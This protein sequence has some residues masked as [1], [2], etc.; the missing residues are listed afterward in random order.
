MKCLVIVF[1]HKVGSYFILWSVNSFTIWHIVLKK[2]LK[3]QQ[4]TITK[5][6]PLCWQLGLEPFHR[7]LKQEMTLEPFN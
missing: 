6:I 1:K 3:K 4:K 5:Y 7:P 2:N